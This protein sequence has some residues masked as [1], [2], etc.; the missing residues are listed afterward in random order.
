MTPEQ[1]IADMQRRLR[2]WLDSPSGSQGERKVGTLEGLDQD[3]QDLDQQLKS[4]FAHEKT[5]L[6]PFETLR[7]Q[8]MFR[9]VLESMM[10]G[11][12]VADMQ[13]RMLV[14]NAAARKLL[15]RGKSDNGPGNWS[16]EFGLFHVDGRT[17]YPS[18][19]LPLTLALGGKKV[20]EE[21]VVVRT[22]ERDY[23]LYLRASA[24]PLWTEQGEQMGAVVVFHDIT[25]TRQKEK[26]LRQAR[27]VAEEASRTKSEFLANMSH[28]IRTP[29]TAV[30]G[31]ADLLLDPALGE[32]DKLNYIQAVRRNGQHLLSL[33]NDVLDLSKLQAEKM[34]VE[35]LDCDLHQI[36]H[37]VASVMQVRAHEKG[38]T[39]DV[40][41]DTPI[42][43]RIQSDPM[44]LRQILLNFL[45]NA[46]K[47]TEK[48]GV[49]LN[50][51][52]LAPGTPDARLV[53]SVSD[54]GIG[55][56]QREINALFQ[57]F[58]QAN[59]STTRQYGG[60]GLGLAI[61]RSLAEM[62]NGEVQV[63]SVPGQ[64]S[65]FSLV[66]NQTI[67]PQAEM[68]Q[69]YS[70]LAAELGSEP[71]TISPGTAL[72]GR[73]LL[74]EDGVDNQL[75]ITTI[76]SRHGLEVDVANNG[77]VAVEKA[78]AAWRAGA[79]YDLIL[80]DMQ[81]PLLDGYGATARLRRKDYPGPIVALTAHAMVGERERCIASGCDDYLT[82]PIARDV[83]IS[84]VASH[85]EVPTHTSPVRKG[86]AESSAQPA[87]QGPL[88]SHYA[89]DPDMEELVTEFVERLPV[90]L[91]ALRAACE[92]GDL[93]QVERLAHQL[94]GAAGGY[95]FQPVSEEA[96]GLESAVREA[97]PVNE[98]NAR[99]ETLAGICHRARS[100]KAE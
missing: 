76:L 32:S 57:P 9:T 34:Q 10:E 33:I 17:R 65:T 84:A 64:G 19:D 97:Q 50:A 20:D 95:G 70:L 83:L 74:A 23:D 28:E 77:E 12:V 18:E 98:I 13:G 60:T 100:G 35:T 39:F 63:E 81:M 94:K 46:I 21:E 30:L 24:R 1:Q 69:E 87:S 3:I 68:V 45:S 59:L 22:P 26:E 44:R 82:K 16:T 96:A 42:P 11:V 73:I 90:R 5:T 4:L 6:D 99:L 71:A 54:T 43:R 8:A 58:H 52:C 93:S 27:N 40:V 37:E 86:V 14:F 2:S 25:D 91:E 55:L 31:F 53:L 51:R 88:Y 72:P 7:D 29:L 79:P 15:G 89:D 56:E 36:L 61:S 38:L 80:M 41:Y 78:L 67:D 49:T 47:F 48:G 85:L 66:L 62:L 75:L 92:G